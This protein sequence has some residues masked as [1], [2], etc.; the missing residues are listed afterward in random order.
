MTQAPA[1]MPPEA[2][3]SVETEQ[4]QQPAPPQ[5]PV[6]EVSPYPNVYTIL[7]FV[8][9]AALALAVGVVLWKL[10][11]DPPSGYGYTLQQLFEPFKPPPI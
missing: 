3:A 7:L 1:E 5:G 2:A 8:A 9:I 4:P 6:V 10:T 11:A